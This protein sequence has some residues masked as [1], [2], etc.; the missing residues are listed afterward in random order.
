MSLPDRIRDY[1]THDWKAYHL[2]PAE[3]GEL[4]RLLDGGPDPHKCCHSETERA[5]E[6]GDDPERF[7]VDWERVAAN[8]DPEQGGEINALKASWRDHLAGS[9]VMLI[10]DDIFIKGMGANVAVAQHPVV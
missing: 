1:R 5:E 4:R 2:S 3:W 9:L 7:Y 10:Y 8:F 6:L